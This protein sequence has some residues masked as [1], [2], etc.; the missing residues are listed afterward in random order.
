MALRRG[1]MTSADGNEATTSQTGSLEI[2]KETTS[3]SGSKSTA[4]GRGG[5]GGARQDTLPTVQLS[6][7][8]S[9][10]LRHGAAKEHLKMAA[11][12][13]ISLDA[14]LA[15]PK[16]SKIKMEHGGSPSQEDVMQVVETNDK[17]RFEVS[18][19]ESGQVF[20]RAVQGHSIS[21]VSNQDFG[22]YRK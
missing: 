6:K 12:G 8:L 19:R 15:R 11:D 22:K 16:L 5:K 3:A 14:V 10:I 21:E 20:I 7:A 1:T 13:Y 4:R 2:D 17:K 9:Y 18:Q